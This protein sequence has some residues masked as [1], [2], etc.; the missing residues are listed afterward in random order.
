MTAAAATSRAGVP[1]C[2]LWD[3]DI[4][5]SLVALHV[6]VIAARITIKLYLC[7]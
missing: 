2:N 1:L 4:S 7:S 6:L 3:D 5:E